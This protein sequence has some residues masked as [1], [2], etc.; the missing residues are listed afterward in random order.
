M[1]I[2]RTVW[3]R[4]EFVGFHRWPQATGKSAYL[5][6]EHRHLFKVY[7]E[8]VT[9]GSDREVEFHKLKADTDHAIFVLNLN[10]P[11]DEARR[12][13]IWSCE[14]MGEEIAKRLFDQ[15]YQITHIS[16][17]EDGE[18]GAACYFMVDGPTGS[19]E[20]VEGGD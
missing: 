7:V 19:R 10:A 17:S 15:G 1:K 3:A 8:A 6:K 9:Q 5:S 4:T 18:C 16:I 20:T 12:V 11:F 14:K 13:L 2:L